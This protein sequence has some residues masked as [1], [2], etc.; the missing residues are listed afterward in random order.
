MK[1]NM[2]S[3]R[4]VRLVLVAVCILAGIAL[5]VLRTTRTY[6]QNQTPIHIQV[7]ITSDWSNRH[8][9]FTT[10]ATPAQAL[11]I[12]KDPRYLRQLARRNAAVQ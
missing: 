2:N 8:V 6:A 1:L 11:K 9:V 3:G 5:W 12:Q 4:A 10:P 7:S